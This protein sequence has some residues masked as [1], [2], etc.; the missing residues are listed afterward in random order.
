MKNKKWKRMVGILVSIALLCSGLVGCSGKG[1]GGSS[2]SVGSSAG[3]TEGSGGD[4]AGGASDGS[5]NGTEAAMGRFLEEE[6]ES[7]ILFANIFDM[8]RMDDGTIRLIGNDADQGKL[9]VWDSKDAGQSWEKAFALSD[10]LQENG[11][12]YVDYAALSNGG[13][14]IV[15]Y[16]QIM[17]GK[18]VMPILYL[19]DKEGNASKIPFEM[20]D[21]KDMPADG[22]FDASVYSSSTVYDSAGGENAENQ[23]T[24]GENSKEEN[25][26]GGSPEEG[27]EGENPEGGSPGEGSEGENPEGGSPEEGS[28]G[29]NP[30]G[31]GSEGE[32]NA[33]G[34]SE[35]YG[36][37]NLIMGLSCLGEDQVLVKD[38]SGRV[39]QISIS[40][41]SIKQTYEFGENS[42]LRESFL[43]GDKLV[44]Q[45]DA[46]VLVYDTA[47]GE[48]QSKEDTLQKSIT[49]SGYFLAVDSLDGGKGMYWLSSKGLFHYMFGGSVMEQLMDGSLNSLANPSFYVNRLLMLDEQNLLVAAND[50]SSSSP[51]GV[52]LVK[53]TY[54]ADTPARPEKELKVYS[55]NDSREMRQA[56]SHYQKEHTD[57]YINYEVALAE[58][59]G[60]TVSDALKTLTTEVMAGKGPDVLILDGMPV[61]TYAEKGILRDLAAIAANAD[62]NYFE[63]ILHAYQDGQGQM[64]AIPARFMMPM[65]HA[66]SEYY[67]PGEG[68]ESFTERKDVLAHM[69]PDSVVEK[70]WYSCGAAWKKEDGTLDGQKVADFLARLK[71]AYGEFDG[72]EDESAEIVLAME[73][74]VSPLHKI[75]LDY[76]EFDLAGKKINAN[77]GLYGGGD[78]G[79]IRAVSKKLEG[80]DFG[81]MPGQAQN[82]FVPSMVLGVSS[83][84]MQPEVAEAFVGYL[85]SADAQKLSMNS[86]FPVDRD[87]FRGVIDGHEYE[88][89]EGQETAG[90]MMSVAGDSED[91]SEAISYEMVPSTEEEI[92]KLTDLAESLETPALM[93][94][95][96]KEAV[97]EQGEKVLKGELEPQAAADAIM[98]KVNIYLAE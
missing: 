13:Q 5:A 87:A 55:L 67:T 56:I 47:T 32:E 34:A 1:N 95:V 61:E 74:G 98:Q 68:F 94:D 60:M 18:G 73:G 65:A 20:P 83:K 8:K 90:V 81:M 59:N 58:E 48:Q 85:L 23:P 30:E 46:E 28:E 29:E 38:V 22:T 82:V 36:S 26:G 25:P 63:N 54:S 62:G 89:K 45:T 17:E 44:C 57:I 42:E 49:E 31:E 14:S 72:G 51:T 39:Y 53:F 15:A 97:V 4:S 9:C 69:E 78:Y 10:E 37:N 66:G 93:D 35:S 91:V 24:E 6:I 70:F 84:S 77:I 71:N 80:G 19:T 41:G 96:I 27:S 92:K 75:S 16:N 88:P 2:D 43:V 50:S 76:G 40:D 52:V 64:C 12:G 79:L 3:G 33:D 7:A 11:D 21:K 86:G